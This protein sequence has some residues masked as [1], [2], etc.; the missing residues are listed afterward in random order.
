LSVFVFKCTD[1]DSQN[2][3]S[4]FIEYFMLLFAFKKC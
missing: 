4:V 1:N 3:I 2:W